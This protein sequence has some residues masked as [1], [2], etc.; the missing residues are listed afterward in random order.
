M[1]QTKD[2]KSLEKSSW[3]QKD[4]CLAF[5]HAKSFNELNEHIGCEGIKYPYQSKTMKKGK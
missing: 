1:F 4:F 3:K 2:T 5:V